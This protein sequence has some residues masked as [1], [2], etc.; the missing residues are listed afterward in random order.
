MKMF[1]FLAFCFIKIGNIAIADAPFCIYKINMIQITLTSDHT[2]Y[3]LYCRC[4]NVMSAQKGHVILLST[5]GN[6]MR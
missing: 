6:G 1:H 4:Q 3:I 5:K 2:V